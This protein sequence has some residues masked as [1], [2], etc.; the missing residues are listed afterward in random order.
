[1][2][3]FLKYAFLMN[4]IMAEHGAHDSHFKHSQVCVARKVMK[5]ILNILC[6]PNFVLLDPSHFMHFQFC[7]VRKVMKYIQYRD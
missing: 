6:I 1:M 5:Y 3:C 2:L 4:I 7:V